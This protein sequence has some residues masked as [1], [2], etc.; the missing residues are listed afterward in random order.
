MEE[1]DYRRMT[2][3]ERLFAAGKLD[4]FDAA[5]AE[6]DF[7]RLIGLLASV[8]VTDPEAVAQTLLAL[9][10]ECWF[11]GQAI[12]VGEDRAIAI[13]LSPLGVEEAS[14]PHQV[15]YAHFDCAAANMKG[16]R[17]R[18]EGDTLFASEE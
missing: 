8:H 10:Y 13:G 12:A 11:C 15:I 1:A 14:A 4:A 2:L 6:R 17:H 18:L 7:D 16:S 9:G 5:V 3:N